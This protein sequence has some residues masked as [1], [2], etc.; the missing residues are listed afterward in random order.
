MQNQKKTDFST[1]LTT[2]HKAGTN[3]YKL[4]R[5]TGINRARLTQWRTGTRKTVDYDSG[6][7][8]MAVYLESTS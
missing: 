6:L 7:L 3:D 4:A 1:I 2:I 8:I 5:Q